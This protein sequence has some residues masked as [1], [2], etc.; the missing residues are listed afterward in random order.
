MSEKGRGKRKRAKSKEHRP[1]TKTSNFSINKKQIN[2]STDQQIDQ[3]LI[4][5]K[6]ENE[7]E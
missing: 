2:K 6:H 5:K 4:K 3:N 7:K 1:K